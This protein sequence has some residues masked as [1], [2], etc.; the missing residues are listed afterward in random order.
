MEYKIKKFGSILRSTAKINFSEVYME[1]STRRSEFFKR[2]KTLI[3]LEEMEKEIKKI[4]QKVKGIKGQPDY[5]GISLFKM[6]LLNYCYDLS[7][8]AT[9]KL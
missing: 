7:D 6:M 2:L 8:I 3:H 1:L 4:Y 9:E 5:S